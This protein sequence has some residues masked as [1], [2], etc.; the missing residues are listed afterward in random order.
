MRNYFEKMLKTMPASAKRAFEEY[1]KLSDEGK[2]A[3]D[4]N[5][6][7]SEVRENTDGG[8]DCDICHNKRQI[9]KIGDNGQIVYT[10]CVCVRQR[11]LYAQMRRSGAANPDKYT[12]DSYKAVTDWQKQIKQKA[13]AF[14]NDDVKSW[15]F[16]GGQVGAGKTHICTA[17]LLDE[18]KRGKRCRYM[19]WTSD[20]IR[21]N[22]LINDRD[23]ITEKEKFT[24]AE[25]LYVDDLFKHRKGDQPTSG[26]FNRAMEILNERYNLFGKYPKTIISSEC[27]T[28]EL[29]KIDEAL[30]SRIIERTSGGFAIDIARDIGKNHRLKT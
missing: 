7:N 2:L 30:A 5:R 24:K 17:I 16:I 8:I 19:S 18:L 14:L 15:F 25:A 3:F 13:I 4:V 9:A 28:A 20:M 27:T 10:D 11:A 23:Y 29:L 1:N 22:A 6:Y 12:F 26:E 21:L